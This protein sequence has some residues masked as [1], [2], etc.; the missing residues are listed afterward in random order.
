MK[1]SKLLL[2][3]VC[4]SAF[5]C[6]E[7]QSQQ[8]DFISDL[9][10]KMTL[11]EKLGQLNQ[12]VAGEINTG[13]PQNTE[14]GKAIM[15]GE[16][17][18][19]FNVISVDKIKELQTVAVEKSRLK[20][21]LLVGMD[22][23]H[24]YQTIFPVPLG[25]SCTW[26]LEKIEKSASI[27][28]KESAANGIAWTFS[29]MVDIS[30]D[31]RWGR[32]A[33]GSGEDPFLGSQIAKAMVRGYQGDDLKADDKILACVK[34]F[35]LY[36]AAE[37]GLDYNT[38]DMSRLRMFNQY[39]DPY[40]AAVEAG[41][42]TVMS[43]FNIVDGVPATANKWLLTD[44][45][46]K[47]WGFD[48]MVVTDYASI[49][50]MQ[51]HGLGE[52]KENSVRALKAGTDMDM[53]TRGFL[54]TLETAIAEGLVSE[55]DINKACR[56]VL[57][58]KQK[59][60]L[61]DNPYKY[62]D[63]KIPVSVTYCAEHKAFAKELTE[64]SFVM[65]KNENNVLPLKK[66]G[67]IALIGPLVEARSDMAGTWSVAQDFSKYSTLKESFEKYLSGSA[68]LLT[69]QGCNLLDNETTQNNIQKGHGTEPILRVDD[70]KA[71]KEAVAVAKKSDVII[72]ALGE[73][74]WMS[75]EGTS[76]SDLELPRP[77]K[78][79][80]NELLKLKKPV[81]LLNF[82][83]RATVLT[84]ES[85]TVPAIMNVWFGSEVGDALC[86]VLFGEKSPSG[87]LTVSMPKSVGQLP[88]YYNTLISGRPIPDDNPEYIIFN[89]D[90][91]DVSNGA[92]YPFGY[93]LS[94]T[95]FEYSGITLSKSQISE[96]E[97]VTA[98][99]TV[100]NT[101]DYDGDEI[102][103]LYIRDIYA[104]ICRPIKELKG[105][106]RISLK[107]GESQEVEFEITPDL[108]KFYNSDLDFVLEKGEFEVM[109][110]GNSK[111]VKREK[112]EVK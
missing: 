56:R 92:L 47:R 24:G 50:E 53:V 81:V 44:V 52:L 3:A 76:R 11:K 45:L 64:E 43:S 86:S 36:G 17:G 61:F 102:V 19:V 70:E 5:S 15:D 2:T 57:E 79:L 29:P 25:L 100:K 37:S 101:G 78:A 58:A 26:D 16:I 40:K 77:Q 35:A 60:G 87:K 98:K 31:P 85:K 54:G 42:A 23:V 104:S 48:G 39:F 91:Q 82:A 27:A 83:G 38:V 13:S 20:I 32:Q 66:A 8:D 30:L 75:G 28:A 84:E 65:L 51:T 93:G 112:F 95:K 6:S 41:V 105:F 109:L 111:E 14:C 1:F 69:A 74:A 97:T 21:P 99:V 59:L 72:C 63:G 7:K 88:L 80:L 22:V 108:L 90:Y 55:D 33:E 9:M 49:A 89:S 68:T 46:R 110:G 18:S 71:L 107:K 10:S 94:Y 34:H 73:C 62:C 106:K 96:N 12:Q 67:T 4:F 103:Q